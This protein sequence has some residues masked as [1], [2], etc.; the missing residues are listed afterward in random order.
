MVQDGT[1]VTVKSGA[2]FALRA[3][4]WRFFNSTVP[5]VVKAFHDDGFKV[6]IFT[7]AHTEKDS[8]PMPNTLAPLPCASNLGR[9]HCSGYRTLHSNVLNSPYFQ[10]H[11]YCWL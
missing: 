4:D 11:L 2:R 5:T 1:L 6:V 8:S 7:C 9:G 3:D 10:L